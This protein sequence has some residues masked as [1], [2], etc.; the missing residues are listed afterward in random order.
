MS[1]NYL[2]PD[3]LE[4]GE[5]SDYTGR[6]AEALQKVITDELDRLGIRYNWDSTHFLHLGTNVIPDST[7]CSKC[8][9]WVIPKE[10]AHPT[11]VVAS[12]WKANDGRILCDQCWSIY[13]GD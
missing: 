11:S 7:R 1:L 8:G 4:S 6:I 10:S 12:G 5:T 3:A 2:F 9:T 13:D